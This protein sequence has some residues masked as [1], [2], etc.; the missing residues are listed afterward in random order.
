M[1]IHKSRS[2]KIYLYILLSITLDTTFASQPE[3]VLDEVEKK[4][5]SE[6]NTRVTE[7]A[8]LMFDYEVVP[9]SGNNSID[10]L[11]IHY[12]HQLNNWLYLGLGVQ[13]PLVH[14]NYGGF[15][16]FDGTVHAQRSIYKN[17]FINAGAAFGGGAG[18]SSADQ[19]RELSGTGQYTKGYL[20]FG[21]KFQTFS[22]GLNYADLRFKNSQINHSQL[23]LFIQK[24]FS[25][26]IGSYANSGHKVGHDR[27]F[28]DKGENILILESN[29]ILQV[30]PKAAH[31]GDIYALS[32]QLSHFL[33]DNQY[34]FLGFDVGYKG[35]PTYNQALGGVGYKVSASPRV[36]IY[37]QIAIGSGGYSPE[38][39]D[40]GPGLLVYPKISIEYL[41]SNNLGLSLSTGY[42]VS[43]KGTSKNFTVGAALNYHL[44]GKKNKLRSKGKGF[45]V[46]F[47]PQTEFNVEVGN[48]KHD[49]IDLLSS[50]IDYLLND[51]WYL[52]TQ[53]S[54]A[55][56]EFLGF[57]GYG[58]I[59]AGLG[60]QNKYYSKNRFQ[61]MFQL[62]A[63]ANVHGILLKPSIGV[64]YSFNDKLALFGQI[65]KTMSVNSHDL[66]PE[67]KKFSAYSIGLGL[68]YRFS[69]P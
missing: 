10:F 13:A 49:R 33:T 9:L 60:I 29:N 4:T 54:I 56:T 31:K 44:S 3:S 59:L 69:L 64:N 11:G 12:L 62:L 1:L 30:D 50:Q 46:S 17:L 40:T 8:M 38:D 34:L 32:L 18:G 6:R 47:F 63:G 58:E 45:R 65:G 23:N 43:P 39:I 68:T 36:N 48:K 2:H 51:H 55:Y 22:I 61:T 26:S 24:P 21:Y 67:D 53:A 52:A 41:L 27:T 66:Y 28:F 25:F 20:G 42:L 7:S 16:A 19:A 5:S 14:G 15:M 37:N 57:P 35:L